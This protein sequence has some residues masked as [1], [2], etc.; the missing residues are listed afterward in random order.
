MRP[1][2]FVVG[3]PLS[4]RESARAEVRAFLVSSNGGQ[5]LKNSGRYVVTV[6]VENA[7]IFANE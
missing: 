6:K 5:D 7:R 3:R 4:H 2:L 1:G